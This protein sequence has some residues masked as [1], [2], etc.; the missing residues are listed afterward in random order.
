MWHKK[1][2]TEAIISGNIAVA[3]YKLKEI[4]LIEEEFSKSDNTYLRN[5]VKTTKDGGLKYQKLLED[6]FDYF[7][8][9]FKK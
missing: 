3:V 9:T 4:E 5:L 6:I 1:E 8:S 2:I 7:T